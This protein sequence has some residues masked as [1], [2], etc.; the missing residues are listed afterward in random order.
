MTYELGKQYEMKVVG[1]QL[2]STGKKYIAL[3]DDDPSKE[4]RVYE[5]LKCQYEATIQEL[6]QLIKDTR[7]PAEPF[8]FI[9]NI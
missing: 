4:Y 1:I 3:H 6:N 2:D 7:L 8:M 9:G 5:I